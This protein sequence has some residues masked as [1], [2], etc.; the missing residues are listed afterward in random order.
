MA[1]RLCAV[2][3]S[4][5]GEDQTAVRPDGTFLR[6]LE[7]LPADAPAGTP[8]DWTGT[9]LLTGATGA[10]GLRTAAWLAS[11][12][13]TRIVAVSRSGAGSP[14][15]ARLKEALVGTGADLVLAACDAADRDALADLLAEHPVDAVVHT[16][17]VLDD[18]LLDAMDA[19]A[20]ETVL[21]PKLAAARNL[22]DLTRDRDLTA[23]VLYSSVSGTLGT[24]GQANYAAANAYLDALAE[25]R[26][27]AGLPATSLAWGPG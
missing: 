8:A 11:R 15:A 13:A 24:I 16:A 5:T 14:G 21:R 7:R 18:R 1:R 3:V 23:F 25:Q 10:L 9:V 22:D 17:G 2:L 27:A 4:G 19:D 26:R 6:R 12:G 20:L